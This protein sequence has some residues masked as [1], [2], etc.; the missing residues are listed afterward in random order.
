M[1]PSPLEIAKAVEDFGC[2][3]YF[4]NEPG[5]R[6]AVMELLE[7][8]VESPEALRWLVRTMIDE[9]GEWQGP[10]ELR[11]VY[12]TR[13]PPADGVEAWSSCGK[14]SPEAIESRA[15]IE[16]AKYRALPVPNLRLLVGGRDRNQGSHDD[17]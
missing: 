1:R 7:R 10:M 16:S 14:F 11:G 6:E 15:A 8:M 13:F 5:A 12:C 17:E 9:V 2:L 4:P 3:R